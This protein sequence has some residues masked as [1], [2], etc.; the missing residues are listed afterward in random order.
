ME[1]QRNQVAPV[2]MKI[3]LYPIVELNDTLI[4]LGGPGLF[5]EFKSED[6]LWS[7]VA[8]HGLTKAHFN[9]L[10]KFS[11]FPQVRLCEILQ[12][13][14]R[15]IQNWKLDDVFDINRSEKMVY[16]AMLFDIADKFYEDRL[17]FAAWL[18]IPSKDTDNRPPVDYLTTVYGIQKL[19]GL[20]WAAA[21]GNYE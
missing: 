17:E 8:G 11:K 1:T 20:L 21:E 2:E 15:T 7:Y 3:G 6:Q 10:V 18:H 13:T 14:A 12:I 9:A 4:P 19:A 16:L 5:P